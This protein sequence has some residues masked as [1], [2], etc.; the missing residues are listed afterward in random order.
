MTGCLYLSTSSAKAAVSPCF[1]RSIRAASGS[2]SADMMS[3]Q[4]TAV[5]RQ[6]PDGNKVSLGKKSRTS[7]IQC[8]TRRLTT[9]HW[10]SVVRCI[11]SAISAALAFHG[12]APTVMPRMQELLKKIEASAAARLTLPPG[13]QPAQE[14]ARYKAFLKVETHRLKLLHRAGGG[15]LRDLPGPRGHPRRRCCAIFGT[16]PRTACP[17]RRRRSSRRWRWWPSA[18]TAGRS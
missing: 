12:F 14:L 5:S 2:G 10:M 9:V 1:T 18:A 11:P 16:P 13:R 15:G 6:T 8:Q 7:D 17:R 4:A 3:N